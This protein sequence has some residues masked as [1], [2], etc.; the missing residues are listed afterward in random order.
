M[1][2]PRMWTVLIEREDDIYVAL[3]AELDLASQG[4][5]IEAARANLRE[6]ITLFLQT[7]R[8]SEAY[9]RKRS[10]IYITSVGA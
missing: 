7:V 9:R 2:K 3:C 5:S 10:E 1:K 4:E 8:P 6:A